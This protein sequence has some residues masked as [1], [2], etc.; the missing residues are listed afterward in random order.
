MK[1][2]HVSKRFWKTQ[3]TAL[4]KAADRMNKFSDIINLSIGD[5]DYITDDAII[6]SAFADAKAGHTK[7]TNPRGDGELLEEVRRFYE[8]EYSLSVTTEELFVTTSSCFGMELSLLAI[9]D[10]GDEVIIFS[11]YFTPYKQQIELAG[12][13]AVEVPTFEHEDFSINADRLIAAITPRTKAVII[14]TPCNPTGVC[15]GEASYELIA[16]VAAEHD[17]VVIADEIYTQYCYE[18]KFVPFITLPGMRERTITLNSFSKNFMMAGWRIGYV[19]A[20]PHICSVMMGINEN[21]VYSSPSISQRAAIYALR[22]RQLV[23][24]QY[25]KEYK[26]RVY[27]ACDRINSIPFLSVRRP[28]GTFY[29]FV[30]ITKTGLSST[31]FCDV[32]FEQC[33]IVAIPGSGFGSA[34]EGY[35]RIACTVGVEK[36]REAFDRI[37]NMSF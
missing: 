22:N 7:Y 2:R 26:N 23:R 6:D 9:L 24:E 17:L 8:E 35:I 4:A 31:E 34:G 36:L 25:I 19:V 12:G 28:D 16:K 29:L 18:S 1:H 20:P 27:Y 15:M 37:E 14:N 3:A 10:A 13:V 11:P 33:H 32:L 5:T 21:M 30:N